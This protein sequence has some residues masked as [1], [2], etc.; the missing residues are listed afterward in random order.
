MPTEPPEDEAY[1]IFYGAAY[2][3]VEAE[4][5]ADDVSYQQ[6]FD[7]GAPSELDAPA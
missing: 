6:F 1:S 3:G 2:L 7:Y 4:A 5:P